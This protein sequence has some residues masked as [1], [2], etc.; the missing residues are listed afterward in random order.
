MK[1]FICDVLVYTEQ[2][3]K[4]MFLEEKLVLKLCVF[5]QLCFCPSIFLHFFL[6]QKVN[7]CCRQPPHVILPKNWPK[8]ESSEI[9]IALSFIYNS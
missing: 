6:V 8:C 4:G 3:Q 7:Y 1:I 2:L 9:G 5:T